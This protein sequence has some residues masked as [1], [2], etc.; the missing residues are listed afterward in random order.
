MSL[1][2]ENKIFMIIMSIS[3]SVVTG[4]E[5]KGLGWKSPRRMS[6]IM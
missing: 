6:N 5:S 2:K 4:N 1:C 3:T